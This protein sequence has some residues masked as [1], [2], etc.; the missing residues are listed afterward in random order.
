M[1]FYQP[2]LRALFLTHYRLLIGIA[3][4]VGIIAVALAETD[5]QDVSSLEQCETLLALYHSTGGPGWKNQDGWNSANEPCD[6]ALVECSDD[7]NVVALNL[8]QNRLKGSLPDLSALTHLEELNLSENRLSGSLPDFSSLTQ[9]KVLALRNNQ[10]SGPLPALNSLTQLETASFYHNQLC[11]QIPELNSLSHLKQL[12]ISQNQL[13]GPIPSLNQLKATSPS[14]GFSGNELC[15]DENNDYTGFESIVNRYPLCTEDDEYP[16]CI[17]YALT[18]SLEGTGSGLVTGENINCGSDCSEQYDENQEI[19][20]DALADPDSS[21]IGWTEAC[22]LTATTC[23]VLMNQTQNVTATFDL[24]AIVDYTLNVNKEGTGSG[25]VNAD[26]ID[27]GS[28]CTEEYIE[29]TDVT[30]TA[31]PATDSTFTG[32]EGI[33]SGSGSCVIS[34]TADQDVIATFELI[35][36]Y[37]LT[38]SKEGNGIG[39]ISGDSIDC[40]S[41]CTEQ[42]QEDATITLNAIPASGSLFIGWTGACSGTETSCQITMTQAQNV[43]AIFNLEASVNQLTLTVNTEGTGFGTVRGEGIDCGSDC[44]EFY[45]ENTEV[46]LNAIPAADSAFAGWS[47]A[48]SGTATACIVP[49]TEAQI[50]TANFIL[51]TSSQTTELEFVGLKASYDVGELLTLDLVEHLNIAPRTSRVDLWFAVEYPEKTFH[52]MTELPL[53][54]FSFTPQP[55]RRDIISSQ[56]AT[57]EMRHHLLYFDVPPGAGGSYHFYA[58]YNQAGADLS[59]LLFTQQ[60]KLA[61]AS[62]E[63]TNNINPSILS[64]PSDSLTM[65]VGEELELIV[66]SEM[67]FDAILSSCTVNPIEIVQSDTATSSSGNGVSCYLIALKP[68]NTTL[69]TTDKNG[70]TLQTLIVVK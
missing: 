7:G 12:D 2:I 37:P 44:R 41:H 15:R 27:C 23:S 57:T 16:P 58:I 39:T 26:G 5:C 47:G 24:V 48:C 10:F 28:D 35:P 31:T 4:S 64:T 65:L 69:S 59:N 33:C 14:F 38:V 56:L 66:D 32:W 13:S 62:T 1:T 40:G 67:T 8:N 53:Q 68:G 46:T 55:Y 25:I 9:L 42:Y 20:L 50:V 22:A 19:T 34:M 3:F 54:P 70:N 63:L 6:F 52:Y 30:V 43:T 21:F 29:N 51:L 11:G 17:Q 60:S 49:F 61:L 45:P 36:S 18:I